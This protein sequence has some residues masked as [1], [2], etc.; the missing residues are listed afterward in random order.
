MLNLKK[1]FALAIVVTATALTGTSLA[2]AYPGDVNGYH[3]GIKYDDMYD[4]KY[5]AI[6]R[7]QNQLI[8]G[9][10]S[11]DPDACY[12]EGTM[13]DDCYDDPYTGIDAWQDGNDRYADEV[14]H[15]INETSDTV[16]HSNT[17]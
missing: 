5:T 10:G 8:N 17:Y 13:Y 9:R 6:D 11:K 15:D 7:W 2:M 16:T 14:R 12:Y 4:D 1:V 3:N